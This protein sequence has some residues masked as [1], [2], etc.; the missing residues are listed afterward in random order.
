MK[1]LYYALAIWANVILAALLVVAALPMYRL[2]LLKAGDWAYIR[3][4]RLKD[5]TLEYY[6][7]F[8]LGI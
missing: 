4:M 1:S 5:K 3:V 2:G 7:R 8:T 6:K